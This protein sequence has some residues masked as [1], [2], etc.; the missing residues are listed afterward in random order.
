MKN[1]LVKIRKEE[2]LTTV[3]GTTHKYATEVT[4]MKKTLARLYFRNL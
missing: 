3:L 2:N 1:V 4:P